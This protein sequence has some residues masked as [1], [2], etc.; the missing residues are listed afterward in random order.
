[1]SYCRT[2]EDSDVYAYH[3]ISGMYEIHVAFKRGG[4]RYK[5][6]WAPEPKFVYNDAEPEITPSYVWH[7]PLAGR[8]FY[9]RTPKAFL[10]RLLIL[11]GLGVRVP[12]RAIDRIKSEILTRI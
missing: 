1:M 12:K 5:K 9:E 3:S 11:K 10:K 8:S 2:S 7:H 6:E 4:V